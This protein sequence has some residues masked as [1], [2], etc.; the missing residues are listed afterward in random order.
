MIDITPY[1]PTIALYVSILGALIGIYVKLSSR[2]VSLETKVELF[3]KVIEMRLPQMLMLK[4]NPHPQYFNELLR[5]MQNSKLSLH[6]MK[7][8][9]DM[10]SEENN[11]DENSLKLAKALLLGR[12][13]QLICSMEKKKK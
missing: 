13:E 7:I 6:E 11:E 8:L 1:V 2:I 9:K 3:W 4:E 10:L 5:K 12:L